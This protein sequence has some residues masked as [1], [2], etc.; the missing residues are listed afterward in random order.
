VV[1]LLSLRRGG[2]LLCALVAGRLRNCSLPTVSVAVRVTFRIFVNDGNFLLKFFF[3]RLRR[4]QVR[5]LDQLWCFC[6]FGSG[7]SILRFNRWPYEKCGGM[8]ACAGMTASI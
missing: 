8:P 5:R 2:I 4:D 6:G 1:V 7:N 3:A